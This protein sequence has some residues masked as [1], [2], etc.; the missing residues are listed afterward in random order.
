MWCVFLQL[1][2]L[3]AMRYTVVF[4]QCFTKQHVIRSARCISTICTYRPISVS[5]C[6]HSTPVVN[7]I[8]ICSRT[9][10]FLDAI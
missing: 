7:M 6:L 10:P 4:L 3:F 8:H 2:F 1:Y 5:F 9:V